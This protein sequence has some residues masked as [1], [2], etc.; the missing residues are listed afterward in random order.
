MT[1]RRAANRSSARSLFLF[2]FLGVSVASGSAQLLPHRERLRGVL[3]HMRLNPEMQGSA[4]IRYSP[5]GKALFVQDA[6]GV[7]LLSRDPLQLVSYIDSPYAYPARFS[8]DSQTLT[9]V[10][11]DLDVSRWTVSNGQKID[12]P[13]LVIPGG[14][15]AASLSPSGDLL[16]CYT[17]EM[18][19]TIYRLADSKKIFSSSLHNAP[20]GYAIVPTPFD[21]STNF[22]SPFGFFPS[23]DMRQLANRG[24]YGFAIW[25]S[26]EEKYVIAGDGNGS[27]R[28]NL[29]TF[30][31]ENLASPVRKHM[32]WISGITQDDRVLLVDPV[33]TEPPSIIS[34]S[35]GQLLATLSSSAQSAALC[36]NS[37][38]AI[39]KNE[40][41][42]ATRLL[43]LVSGNLIPLRQSI[44]LDIRENEIAALDRDAIVAFYKLGESKPV[45]AVRLPLGSLPPLRASAVDPSLSTLALAITGTGRTFDVATGKASISDK[46]FVG[47]NLANPAHPFFLLPP[48]WK[49]PHQVLSSSTETHSTALAWSAPSGSEIHPGEAAFLEY[50][51]QHES[52]RGFLFGGATSGFPFKLRGLDPATG[53][54]LW[55]LHFAE[56]VPIPFC[57]PQG[58]RFVLG[59]KAKSS[60]ARLAVKNNPAIHEAYKH[61]K[62]M[63][64]DSVFEVYD[65]TT[66]KS[67]GGV[68][69]QFG[70]GPINFTS[71][72]SVGDFVFLVKDNLRLTVLSLRDGKIVTR[73]KGYQP[74]ASAQSNLFALDEGMGRLGIYDLLT[75]QKIEEQFFGHNLAYKHF[76]A[77]GKKLLVLAA[78]Q[79]VFVLDMSNV[80]EHPLV[81]Q[82]QTLNPSADPADQPQ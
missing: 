62:R 57:D 65:S 8:A 49:L 30:A 43:D 25:F 46:F 64:Q 74:A 16:A 2:V 31:K 61:S 54:Q 37:R 35:T 34:L 23:N 33:Q 70:D 66:G 47:A 20:P 79:E 45:T 1:L 72:F 26:P 68:F 15:L 27:I 10:S 32:R 76:S 5:D 12:T 17:P 50:S 28:V 36:S 63:E 58:N 73:A 11:Y 24:I 52:S 78:G 75:G 82:R 7:M 51:L 69:V 55:Q 77:D 13:N 6:A 67:L 39:L 81:P 44:A 9:L 40:P 4:V 56:D 53:R 60:G 14:C 3:S 21:S 71:A 42:S 18:D 80:R 48:K 41:E 38:Y 19:L 29:S 59:W 22:S